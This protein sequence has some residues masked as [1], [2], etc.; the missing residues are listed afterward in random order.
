MHGVNVTLLVSWLGVKRRGNPLSLKNTLSP[1]TVILEGIPHRKCHIEDPQTAL[2][3]TKTKHCS[4]IIL[5]CFVPRNDA[6]RWGVLTIKRKSDY[7][8]NTTIRLSFP[9]SSVRRVAPP[10]DD[11][12]MRTLA[13][14]NP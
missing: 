11:G 4:F 7:A 5:D 8:E 1:F 12:K 9:G 13:E 3:Q 14:E 6:S 2:S 10:K